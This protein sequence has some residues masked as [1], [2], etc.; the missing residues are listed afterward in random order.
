MNYTLQSNSMF[1]IPGML[2]HWKATY[3]YDRTQ[4]IIHVA[5]CFPEMPAL[6]LHDLLSGRVPVRITPDAAAEFDW[7]K[8]L[9]EWLDYYGSRAER[10]E[11]ASRIIQEISEQVTDDPCDFADQ[12]LLKRELNTLRNLREELDSALYA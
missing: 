7:E 2:N 9:G 11:A 3:R 4:A 5:Y 10:L 6:L 12:S 1:H 8:P